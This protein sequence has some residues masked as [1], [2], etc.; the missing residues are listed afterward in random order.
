[1]LNRLSDYY[2]IVNPQPSDALITQRKAAITAFE[3]ELSTREIQY[4]CAEI[5]AFGIG[6][7][8]TTL[9]L[10][11]AEKIIA[12][13]QGEQPSFSSDIGANAL[14]LRVFAAIALGDYI[15]NHDG[16]IAAA[17]VI[18]ALGT[19]PLPPERYLSELLS[20]LYNAARQ[21]FQKLG[22][23][24]RRRGEL[25][26][27]AVQGAE[28]PA[29]VKSL[30]TAVQVF[31]QAVDH[32][33]RI[34]R[35]ELDVLW[36]IFGGHSRSLGT[37]F[38][39]LETPQRILISSSE[40]A[41]LVLL[42]PDQ[43]FIQFLDAILK[44]APP[45]TLR[46]LIEPCP[47]AVLDSIVRHNTEKTTFLNHPALLPVTWL[48]SRRLESGMVA[49]WESEFEQKTHIAVTDERP[50]R[51]WAEQVFN[52]CIAAKLIADSGE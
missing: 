14:D 2:R 50:A 10:T 27:P 35:E 39:S 46:Q 41:D 5:A 22:I 8:P 42:P 28:I 32:S 24:Q 16:E 49:G 37:P 11:A 31:R 30:N 6:A 17:L 25:E 51:T 20:S 1:M 12:S 43:G 29:L 52:E 36:W 38:Q 44:D 45:L 3:Q 23:A 47:S 34:D 19:R 48:S 40:L 18:C 33:S 4:A 26:F 9:Q 21:T 13:I 15:S 7:T